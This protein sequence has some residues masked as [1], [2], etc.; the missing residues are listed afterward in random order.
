MNIEV[1]KEDICMIGHTGYNEDGNTAIICY[2]EKAK[3]EYVLL[4][5]I[6]KCFGDEYKII[7]TY[8]RFKDDRDLRTATDRVFITNLPFDIYMTTSADFHFCF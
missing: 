7:D 6:L 5:S 2:T 8:E 3:I 1:R 4:R